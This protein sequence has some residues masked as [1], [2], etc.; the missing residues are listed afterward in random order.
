VVPPEGPAY[1]H[2]VATRPVPVTPPQAGVAL[3][4]AD[5]ARVDLAEDDPRV[6][7]FRAA[8]AALLDVRGV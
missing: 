7:R 1:D 6:E 3:G 2:L 5:G 8:A 4:F